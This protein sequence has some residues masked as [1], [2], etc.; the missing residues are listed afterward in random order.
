M[1][2]YRRLAYL[3]AVLVFGLATSCTVVVVERNQPEPEPEPPPHRDDPPRR[4]NR[5]ESVMGWTKLGQ[6]RV[7]LLDGAEDSDYISVG[8]R[9]GRFTRIMLRVEQG[10]IELNDMV[11]V[12]GDGD[13]FEPN[14][15][16][17]FN[18]NTGSRS[19]DLPGDARVIRRVEFRY[20]QLGYHPDAIVELWAKPEREFE[21]P[22]RVV[23][24][25]VS[26]RYRGWE[27][28]GTRQASFSA[29][30]DSISVGSDEGRFTAILIE[31][32][33]GDLSMYDVDINFGGGG[34]Y[35]PTVRMEFNEGSRTGSID[36]PGDARIIDEVRF[37]YR[38][39]NVRTGRATVNLYGRREVVVVTPPPRVLPPVERRYPGWDFLGS[40]SA[41]FSSE[42]DTIE[43]GAREGYFRAIQIEV[44]DGD[45]EMYQVKV[46][47]TDNQSYS[48]RVTLNFR[49]DTRTGSIDLPGDARRIREVQFKYR[50]SNVRSGMA[51]V[52]L[53]GRP[54][55][56]PAAPPREVLPP[57]QARYRGW[58][59]LG[60]RTADFRNDKDT[61]TVGA[62][63]GYFSAIKIEVEDAD[64]E[65]F[66]IKIT[67]GDG[68]SHSPNTRYDFDKNTR[69]RDIDLPGDA[70]IISKVEFHYKTDRRG[71]GKA[72]VNLYGKPGRAPVI[73]T[74]PPRD[75]PRLPDVKDRY[76]GWEHLGS[77]TADHKKDKDTI[78]VGAREGYFT[79]IRLEVEDNELELFDMIVTFGDGE[80][81]SPRTKYMFDD[82]TRT[83]DIDLP[84]DARIITK[85]EFHYRTYRVRGD[86]SVVNLYGKAGKAPVVT[87]PRELPPVASR[88]RGWNHLGARR[89]DFG[90]DKDTIKVTASEG[91]FTAIKLEVEDG[92][93]ELFNIKVTFGDGE[94]FKPNTR[95]NF[96]ENSRSRD[97]DLPGG[98]RVIKE[99]EFH[100]KS[101][102]RTGKATLNLYGKP[103]PAGPMPPPVEPPA[104][105]PVEPPPHE[106]PPLPPVA[107]RY[108]GWDHLGARRADFG[109]DK[110][111]I[112][113]TA[114]EG[115]FTAIKLEVEDGDLELFNIK[116]TFGDGETFKP[117]T[118]YNFDE[119]SRSRD[120]DL[121]GG[122]RVIKEVEFHY[123]SKLRTGKAT[124]NLYG[125]AAAATPPPRDP[126][127]LPP[128]R[129]RFA[130]WE[131]LGTRK[132]D[133]S[134]DKDTLTVGADAGLFT[135]V[136]IEVEDADLEMFDMV[137]KTGDGRDYD[138]NMR[139]KFDEDSRSRDITIPGDGKVIKEITFKYKSPNLR[140]GRA[141]VN[142]YG[143]KAAAT[144]T[145][146][147]P[148]D[149]YEGWVFLGTRTV[150]FR[151]D[152]DTLDIGADQGKFSAIRVE[153]EEG[154]IELYD[155][156]VTFSNGD[157]HSPDTRLKFKDNTRTRDI[158]L[159][160]RARNIK[161]I[162]FK[163]KST[164]AREGRAVVNV[165]GKK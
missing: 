60:S 27:Y 65:L 108:R 146:K 76:R 100:H 28:L 45:L 153:V 13:T 81:F 103:A 164:N 21:P 34:S 94:T 46:I 54:G 82:D 106:P 39:N 26:E 77:R 134:K 11:V 20:T 127:R 140:Q 144:P 154:D 131:Y 68:K 97:I 165:Y 117:N 2:H 145:V 58:D 66:N 132:A 23:L 89:A 158:D 84:G 73:V 9:E 147:E 133:F 136:K 102:L 55:V 24:P 101:K 122:A 129:T 163:Y 119:N 52:N 78:S 41:S 38:S 61:I 15:R 33:D 113:V 49:E 64:L 92:D 160:G 162:E 72:I 121:P 6:R 40:R 99:V 42:R 161:K 156:K 18:E 35:S 56:P 12:F 137:I 135:A 79:S 19:I 29:E 139:F 141:T 111:T 109:N 37:R 48:P 138:A 43:V 87:P 151:A 88:Y 107:G 62:R 14:L 105:P 143:K 10:D 75:P 91:K 57:V 95:Y 93:L 150:N 50:S 148:K 53:Y 85:V 59:H 16:A 123:K 86:K 1:T 69:S 80:K 149:R 71:S 47:F 96:D 36:L 130:G 70:R 116:V 159:P 44:E 157:P 22:P 114:S 98:A 124:L 8:A 115:K 7:D 125:K 3:F 90:N 5:M 25:H 120:I 4:S 74:P 110:D 63:E 112:K 128:V 142:V 104:L 17:V 155:L 152:K 30:R 31:V 67:F 51:T 118:R 83:R 126:P 32:E